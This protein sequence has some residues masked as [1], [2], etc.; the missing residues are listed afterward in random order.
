MKATARICFAILT[1]AGFCTLI[2]TTAHAGIAQPVGDISGDWTLPTTCTLPNQDV[3]VYDGGGTLNQDGSQVVG[4]ATLRLVSGPD[5]CPMELMADVSGILDGSMLFGTLDGGQLGMLDF[6]AQVSQD[7]QMMQ[8]TSVV[9]DGEPFQGTTC[10]WSAQLRLGVF[11][12]PTLGEGALALLAL[13][14]LG[15]GLVMLRR[16]AVGSAG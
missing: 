14:L 5:S 7:L 12:I 15:G 11:A 6:S 2:P 10:T 16:R 3:C 13:L 9:P 8:G 1:L 4:T